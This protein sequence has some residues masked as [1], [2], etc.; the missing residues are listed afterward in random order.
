MQYVDLMPLVTY[1]RDG[2]ELPLTELRSLCNSATCESRCASRPVDFLLVPS[3]DQLYLAA[4]FSVHEPSKTNPFACS[5]VVSESGLRNVEAFLWALDQINASPSV[6]PGATLGAVLFDVCGS[7]EKAYRDVSNFASE[8]LTSLRSDVVLPGLGKV[9]GFVAGGGGAAAGAAAEV[10]SWVGLPTVAPD[11]SLTELGRQPRVL[12]VP[13]SNA[14][15]AQALVRLVKHFGWTYISVVDDGEEE[16]LDLLDQLERAAKASEVRIAA[17][18]GL[19]DGGDRTELE[20]AA[21]QLL[22]KQKEGAR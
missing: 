1:S 2:R 14:E 5:S 19:A 11:T 16:N 6:L 21:G 15:V 7:R 10:L 17:S 22:R 8:T 20:E 4:S 3:M 18:V 12:H 13:P 9:F